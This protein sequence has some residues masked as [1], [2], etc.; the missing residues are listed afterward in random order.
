M[1]CGSSLPKVEG[2][3]VDQPTPANGYIL[4]ELASTAAGK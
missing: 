4:G 1:G 3:L 2:F